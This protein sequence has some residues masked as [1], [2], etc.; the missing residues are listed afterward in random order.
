MILLRRD[1]WQKLIVFIITVVAFTN[2]LSSCKKSDY[3]AFVEEFDKLYIDVVKNIDNK[4]TYESIHRLQ[5]EDNIEKIK[6]I[7]ELIEGI[8]DKV[9]K[10][11]EEHYNQLV[12]QYEGI[13]FLKDCYAKWDKLTKDEKRRINREIIWA[14]YIYQES[15]E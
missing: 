13:V 9:P 8:K 2:L 15:Q 7:G 3:N 12:A 1:K 10:K 5:S 11:K 6:N 4:N 14:C